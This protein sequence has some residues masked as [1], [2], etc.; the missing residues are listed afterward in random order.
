MSRIE[1]GV[2]TGTIHSHMKIAE[3]LGVSLPELYKEAVEKISQA[4]EKAVRLKLETFSHSSG[5]VSELLTSNIFQKK[6]MPVLLKIE[7]KGRTETEELPP[8]AERFVH[9]LK[10]S[11]EIR[12]DDERKILKLGESLYFNGALP[13]SFKNPLNSESACLSV[14]SPVAL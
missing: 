12:L 7:P 6:M 13:H 11:V 8:G 3:V 1:N 2:M 9:V 4:K 10:G 14:T 5:A